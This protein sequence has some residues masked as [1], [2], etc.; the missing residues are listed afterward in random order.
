[1]T[2]YNFTLITTIKIKT[3]LII[4]FYLRTLRICSPQ[5]LDDRF[6]YTEDSFKSLK[7]PKNFIPNA[8]KKLSIYTHQ[9]ILRK[10]PPI[11]PITHIPISLPNNIHNKP[12][13]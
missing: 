7:Y 10:T 4:A 8:R 12:F 5:Y 6:R 9:F 11:I 13:L 3:G 2:L 1:M